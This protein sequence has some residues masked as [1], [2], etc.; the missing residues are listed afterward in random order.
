[1][2]SVQ[3][4]R[5]SIVASVQEQRRASIQRTLHPNESMSS[6]GLSATSTTTTSPSRRKSGNPRPYS[7]SAATLPI[8]DDFALPSAVTSVKLTVAILPKVL[9]TSDHN[10]TLDPSP[11]YTWKGGDDLEKAQLA[12]KRANL[13]FVVDVKVTGPI[14]ETIDSA[15]Q[16]HCKTHNISYVAAST[17]AGSVETPNTKSWVLLGPRGRSGARTWVEDPKCLTRFT[18]TL[19][20]LRNVPFSYTPNYLGEAPRL[21][22]L[23]GPIDCLFDLTARL[24]DHVLVHTCLARRVLHPIL[25]SLDGDPDSVCGPSCTPGSAAAV[26]APSPDVYVLS[27]SD[28]DFPEAEALI[29][30]LVRDGLPPLIRTDP[31][32]ESRI[33]SAPTS[34]A[35]FCFTSVLDF[36][37][38]SFRLLHGLFGANSGRM[39][40]RPPQCRSQELVN[41]IYKCTGD[42]KGNWPK[43]LKAVLFAMRV[44]TSRATGFSP[45][46][47]LYGVHPTLD[48]HKVRTHEELLAIRALQLSRRD[49]KLEEASKKLRETRK[50][51]IEDFHKRHHFMFDFSD[52][53]EGMWVWLRESK[54]DETKGDKEKWTY[55]GP[56]IIHQKRDRDSF[57]LRELSGAILKGH[58]NI[59]RLRLF[60]YR[61][62]HQTLR[63]SLNLPPAQAQ[64]SNVEYR[65]DMAL[66]ALLP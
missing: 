24:P 66:Q 58:V 64:L 4:Q 56:Y 63:T 9:D 62:D 1:M 46:Y 36:T 30:Q 12:L 41:A 50:R 57:V 61:P 47:L 54:L 23:H 44:T 55:S 20:A 22:N 53:V 13:V 32:A 65:L 42:A 25:A 8:L 3:N 10:D 19:Q 35:S 31:G 40:L 52:Y 18:F 2:A 26:R 33:V 48:W 39:K 45:Y 51:A 43:F 38:M 6:S 21:R 60:Y 17:A 16:A 11:R 14:F 27:D 28:D 7:R 34:T 37:L 49:P 15:F 29:D 5:H 59:R